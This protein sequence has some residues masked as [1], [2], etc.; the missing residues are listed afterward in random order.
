M[1]YSPLRGDSRNQIDIS[2]DQEDYSGQ[3][4]KPEIL[5]KIGKAATNR[6]DYTTSI[7]CY[8]K[9]R[10][11]DPNHN[12]A[13]FL[14]RR[15]KYMANGGSDSNLGEAAGKSDKESKKKDESE[16]ESKYGGMLPQQQ[17]K[18]ISI[19]P[20][21]KFK[22]DPNIISRDQELVYGAEEDEDQKQLEKVSKTVAIRTK[23]SILKRRGTIIAFA[24]TIGIIIMIVVGLY[25]FGFLG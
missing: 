25:A 5:I 19:K 13:G 2:G 6:N 4:Y 21:H 18:H 7:E 3:L 8:E 12:E 22:V 1:G 17:I 15:A 14:L 23:G 9:V 11:I 10:Q 16:T 20:K 24:L